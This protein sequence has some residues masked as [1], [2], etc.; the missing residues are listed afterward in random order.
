M[1]KTALKAQKFSIF[2]AFYKQKPAKNLLRV[3]AQAGK[4]NKAGTGKKRG[5]ESQGTDLRQREGEAGGPP[6]S[7][8]WGLVTILEITGD[9]TLGRIIIVMLVWVVFFLFKV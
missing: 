4:E 1:K 8:V 3:A 2:K 6:P 5:S 7:Q 9:Q